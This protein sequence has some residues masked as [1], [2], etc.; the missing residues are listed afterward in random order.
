MNRIVKST[1]AVCAA[2]SLAPVLRA[3]EPPGE[4]LEAEEESFFSCGFDNDL[5]SAYIDKNAV[6]SD[7]LVWQPCIWADFNVFDW[8][9]IGGYVWQNWD[10]TA[11]PSKSGRPRAMNETDLN[12][13]IARS[14]WSS[15]DGEYDLSLEIG[16][17]FFLYRQ[18]EELPNGYEAYVRLTFDNPF[19]GVYG[20]YV[21]A[22][23]PVS[24]PYFELGF[25]KEA[26]LA[27]I[28]SSENEFLDRWTVGAEWS[29][30][31]ASGKYFTE[32]L[33]GVLP[34]EYDPEEDEYEERGMSNGIGGTTLK[35][36]VAYQVCDHFS[37][38]LVIAYTAA[39]SGEACD[40]LDYGE[41]GNMYKR[42][43][44]GGLQAKLD[45]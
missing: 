21:Q 4:E 38:G 8:F 36:T 29:L 35:G 34:G 44:W 19:V 16:N 20:K 11:D 9:T 41:C 3:A 15:E 31:F 30:S 45:F 25:T 10:L 1:I 13:H 24:A 14:L 37:L 28:F 12:V 22:Y 2:L 7:E 23:E 27:E 17:E 39:L 32:Y 40:A 33:Y 5:L 18:Q 43:V 26:T 42:L 6:V